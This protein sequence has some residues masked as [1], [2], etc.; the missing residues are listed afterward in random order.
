MTNHKPLHDRILVRRDSSISETA[1]GLAL[2]EQYQ[3]RPRKGTVVAIGPGR[4][5][6]LGTFLPMAIKVGDRVIFGKYAGAEL[7]LDG[8]RLSVMRESNIVCVIESD[9]NEVD[10]QVKGD[11]FVDRG[12]HNHYR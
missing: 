11:V 6:K 2:P 1:C 12:V 3:Q 7:D 4:Q 10:L 9:N 8:E 5:T